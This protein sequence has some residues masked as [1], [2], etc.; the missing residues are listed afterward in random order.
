[1]AGNEVA[2]QGVADRGWTNSVSHPAANLARP[3]SQ[4][5]TLDASGKTDDAYQ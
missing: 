3:N 2:T 4:T 5:R 1:M